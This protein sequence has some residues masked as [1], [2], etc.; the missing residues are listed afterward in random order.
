M[1]YR[2]THVHT[3]IHCTSILKLHTTVMHIEFHSSN[4]AEL[5]VVPAEP[6]AGLAVK[7]VLG[8]RP[9][10]TEPARHLDLHSGNWGACV[11]NSRT[12]Q[13]SFLYSYDVLINCLYTG[14]LIV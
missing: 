11:N 8:V 7:M 1:Q 2:F 3:Y 10:P 14:M 6:G 13:N 12:H 9:S 4:L 5:R